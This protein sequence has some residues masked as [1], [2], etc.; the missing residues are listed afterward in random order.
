MPQLQGAEQTRTGCRRFPVGLVI[1]QMGAVAGH[2]HVL[3]RAGEHALIG[4]G[5]VASPAPAF[6]NS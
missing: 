3:Q 5:Q 1:G 2:G 4:L 6:Y